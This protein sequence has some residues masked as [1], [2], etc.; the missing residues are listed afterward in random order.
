MHGPPPALEIYLLIGT[1]VSMLQRKNS[2]AIISW[3]FEL[4]SSLH[5]RIYFPHAVKNDPVTKSAEMRV[6]VFEIKSVIKV[7]LYHIILVQV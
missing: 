3:W 5:V 1:T 2:N 6:S 4:S 7:V